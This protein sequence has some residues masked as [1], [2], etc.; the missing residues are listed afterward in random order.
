M[1]VITE[2]KEHSTK[3]QCEQKID[4][5]VIGLLVGI[6]KDLAMVV[7][8]GNPIDK[9]MPARSLSP[10]SVADI[11]KEVALLFEAGDAGKPLVV[12]VVHQRLGEL[13]RDTPLVTSAQ[14][15][16]D[17]SA[18]NVSVDGESVSLIAKTSITMSCG[19]SSITMT[20][21]GKI[22]IKGTY[23]ST[24][25]SGVNRIKGGSVQIN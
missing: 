16:S 8:S 11:G 24:R 22:I 17:S 21:A 20:K 23:I 6:E 2:P 3:P 1:T 18:L 9:A 13:P 7:Y 15:S 25:S 14:N 4:G 12:G 10:L 5:V 19:R